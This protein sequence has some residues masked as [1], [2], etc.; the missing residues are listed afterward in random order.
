MTQE[1]F[2]V[3]LGS[4]RQGAFMDTPSRSV[5]W[6][7]P[8]LSLILLVALL[9]VLWIGGGA[10]RADALGQTVVR[11]GTWLFV[12]VAI[13]FNDRPV[14]GVTRPVAVV[15]LASVILL[16]LQL[17]PLP[18]G[19]WA[20]FP[21][22]TVFARAAAA[23]S[24]AQPWRP[25]SISPGATINAL[26]SLI[27]PV[28]TLFFIVGLRKS[29]RASLPVLLLGLAAASMLV[30]ILQLAG[31]SLDN[32][33]INES[34]LQVSGTFANRNHFALF[35]AIGCLIAPVWA[36]LDGRNPEWRGPVAL[37]LMLLFVLMIL[38]SGSRAGLVLGLMALVLGPVIA[39]RG[40]RSALN[41]YPS[42]TFWA[43]IASIVCVFAIFVLASVASNR[44]LSIDRIFWADE[45]QDMRSRGLPTV[46]AMIKDYFPAGTGY[47]TFDPLF[48]LHEPY[49]LLKPTYFNHAHNDFLE[50][51]LDGGLPGGLLLAGALSWWV[52]ASAR[53]W[54]AG[55]H[56]CHAL[57]KLGSAVLLLIVV[58][59]AFDYPSR[60]PVIM[61][62][63][64]VAAIW[65]SEF[66]GRGGQR[67]FTSDVSA[68]IADG[69]P[70]NSG[71]PPAHA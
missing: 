41:G 65:L 17:V 30:G 10:S 70:G 20:A 42:W 1:R 43:L 50:V 3:R 4:H 27:V 19:F 47:G 9:T 48:R 49:A 58:A 15:L 46:L 69:S 45:G 40:I 7:R 62:V 44:A 55:A 52:W 37:G 38:A 71:T 68:S 22:R 61:A 34:A 36:T 53:A 12:V 33:L 64:V 59:S 67:S 25:L 6:F 35:L 28:A 23:S 39:R 60:T 26:S 11:T 21:G 51:L 24:Q 63:A 31:T 29:E 5:A 2:R 13:L 32:P 16:T 57:P 56:M 54:Q 8:S 66:Q 18:P 14:V